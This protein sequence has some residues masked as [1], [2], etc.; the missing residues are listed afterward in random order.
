[1]KLMNCQRNAIDLLPFHT[2]AQA[3]RYTHRYTAEWAL[4]ARQYVQPP[5]AL[6]RSRSL[7]LLACV[8]V[9]VHA[10]GLDIKH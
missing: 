3:Y 9:W 5:L 7:A 1:M 8:P 6:S 4:D 2:H 10:I